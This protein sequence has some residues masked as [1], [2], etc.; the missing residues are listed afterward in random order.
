MDHRGN[1][2]TDNPWPR[3]KATWNGVPLA[4]FQEFADLLAPQAPTPI[5]LAGFAPSSG[6]L[7]RDYELDIGGCV[8]RGWELFKNNMGLLFVA[9]LIYMLIEGVIAGLA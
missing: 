7:E 3:R 2:S 1:A 9:V 5:A 6:W 4:Q 8:S